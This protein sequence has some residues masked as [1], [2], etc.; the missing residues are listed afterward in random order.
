MQIVAVYI[1]QPDNLPL[2][3]GETQDAV[4]EKIFAFGHLHFVYRVFIC[5][6]GAPSPRAEHI[7]DA[8]VH[9]GDDQL[10]CPRVIRVDFSD[11]FRDF[12]KCMMHG[13]FGILYMV[14]PRIGD[15]IHESAIGIVY[16]FKCRF[17]RIGRNHLQIDQHVD[18]SFAVLSKA[19]QTVPLLS[20][21]M[22]HSAASDAFCC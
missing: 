17:V 14:Q 18:S 16:L 3:I 13:V 8:I 20:S 10:L 19:Y 7:C 15:M 2:Q 5:A 1:F 21:L 11:V 6:F 9:D 12:D 4:G 22:L